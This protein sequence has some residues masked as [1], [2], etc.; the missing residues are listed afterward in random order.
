MNK[1]TS[2]IELAALTLRDP[3]W[4][5]IVGRDFLA[6]G[7]FY[8]SVPLAES[9]SLRFTGNWRCIAGQQV[10]QLVVSIHALLKDPRHISASGEWAMLTERQQGIAAHFVVGYDR[11]AKQFLLFDADDPG[12]EAFSTTGWVGQE[13]I[14]TSIDRPDRNFPQH[15]FVYRIKD[16]RLFTVSWELRQE[17]DWKAQD[18]FTCT[19]QSHDSLN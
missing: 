11:D 1:T 10:A 4:E 14:L 3:R 17:G 2:N 16:A 5:S 7:K 8:Y 18:A 19:K 13:M 6:D 15:R 12:Y 9:H